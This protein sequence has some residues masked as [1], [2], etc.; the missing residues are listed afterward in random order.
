VNLLVH[1]PHAATVHV[2]LE[3]PST[4]EEAVG[5]GQARASDAQVNIVVQLQRP[6]GLERLVTMQ[7][8]QTLHDS[9]GMHLGHM[10]TQMRRSGVCRWEIHACVAHCFRGVLPIHVLCTGSMVSG[11]E[12]RETYV[13]AMRRELTSEHA[14]RAQRNMTYVALVRSFTSVISDARREIKPSDE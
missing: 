9:S 2:R 14:G 10:P 1:R 7:A 13:D 11:C 4:G 3:L 8:R 12:Q 5:T 6:C